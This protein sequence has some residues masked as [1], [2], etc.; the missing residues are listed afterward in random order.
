MSIDEKAHGTIV[1]LLQL[2]LKDVLKWDRTTNTESLTYGT[3]DVVPVAFTSRVADNL[4]ALFEAR[5]RNM[6]ADGN[7]FWDDRVVLQLIDE[8]GKPIWTFPP[9][10]AIRTLLRKVAAKAS[11]VEE[12]LD[13]ILRS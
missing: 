2:T 3:N 11:G 9:T 7:V 4:F 8:E 12:R 10:A 6:D 1:K 5:F 13:K